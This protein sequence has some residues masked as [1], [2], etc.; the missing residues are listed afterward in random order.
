[1]LSAPLASQLSTLEV[2]GTQDKLPLSQLRKQLIPKLVGVVLFGSVARAESHADSDV[3]LLLVFEAGTQIQREFY[4]TWDEIV[5]FDSRLS[6]Q[7]VSL[8]HSPH[9]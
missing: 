5:P 8:P 2:P 7:F 9:D 3:D 1:R 4:K 6:P